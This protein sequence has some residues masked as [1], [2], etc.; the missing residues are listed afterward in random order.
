VAALE[1]QERASR[2]RAT[3]LEG[4]NQGIKEELAQAQDALERL[5]AEAAKA[6]PRPDAL[7]YTFVRRGH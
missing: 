2:Q 7:G 1:E 3:E 4:E 5:K 6:A